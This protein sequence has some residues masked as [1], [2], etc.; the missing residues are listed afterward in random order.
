[1]YL[2]SPASPLKKGEKGDI[3]T[4]PLYK[5]QLP[6]TCGHMKGTL[7]RQKLAK[8]ETGRVKLDV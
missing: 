2:C 3:W 1:M 6:V 7:V 5:S 8:G 4:W